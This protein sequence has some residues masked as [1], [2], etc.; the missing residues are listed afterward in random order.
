MV[1]STTMGAFAVTLA[2]VWTHPAIAEGI[3]TITTTGVA[4]SDC[5]GDPRTPLCALD[6]W[7]ACAIWAD[8][9]LCAPVGLEGL[10]F[11]EDGSDI[12]KWHYTYLPTA[13][14]KIE[15]R[16]LATIEAGRVALPPEQT[17]FQPGYVDIRVVTQV[18]MLPID[19]DCA[20]F[21]NESALIVKPVGE[22]WH[23]AG[24]FFE[25]A[26]QAYRGYRP[27]RDDP[28]RRACSLHISAWEFREYGISRRSAE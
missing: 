16:H 22:E 27:E 1:R 20:P 11:R 13:I 10:R 17:W 5:I 14:L 23:V 8:P 9:S 25:N 26:D 4:S 6:T 2:M 3:R 15:A 7:R 28:W 19:D 24:W 21:G 12:W 18:C